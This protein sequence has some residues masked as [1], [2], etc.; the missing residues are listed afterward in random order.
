M[1]HLLL[2]STL[3]PVL[4]VQWHQVCRQQVTYGRA[5]MLCFMCQHRCARFISMAA[6][7]A[8]CHIYLVRLLR[9]HVGIMLFIS[10]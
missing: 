2:Q 7:L 5:C 4:I 3:H 1:L 9:L 10:M 6:F 8:A